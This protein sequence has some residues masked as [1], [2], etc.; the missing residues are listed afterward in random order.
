MN[1]HVAQD[2]EI[3]LVAK[4]LVSERHYGCLRSSRLLTGAI[5]PLR[6]ILVAEAEGS[7]MEQEA[8]HSSYMELKSN[9]AGNCAAVNNIS[10]VHGF[11]RRS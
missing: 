3:W 8:A 2:G 5:W 10:R 4:N 7:G 9:S 11:D 1:R 6:G